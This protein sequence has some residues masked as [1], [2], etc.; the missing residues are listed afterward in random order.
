MGGAVEKIW[1]RLGQEFAKAGNVVVHIS[2]SHEELPLTEKIEGVQHVRVQ[3]YNTP[4]SI[5]RLKT[6]DFIYSWRACRKVPLDSEVVITNTF[7]SPLLL[8]VP[9]KSRIWVSVERMPQGQMRWYRKAR[10]RA[11]SSA[12]VEA[13]Y[14]ELPPNARSRVVMI[15]NP[16]PF[17]VSE[18]SDSLQKQPLLL[19]CGRVHPEKGIHLLIQALHHLK[20]PWPLRVV[21]PWQTEQGGGGQ[22]YKDELIEM[23]KDLPVEWVGPIHDPESLNREYQAAM[24]FIYPSVAERGETFGSAPLEAMAWGCVPIVSNLTCF[25]DFIRS[26]ENGLH[27]DHRK[28]DAAQQLAFAIQQLIDQASLRN[29]LA[30]QAIRVRETHSSESIARQFLNDFAEH[31]Q[32]TRSRS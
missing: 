9:F 25:K 30:R 32:P 5:L 26:G 12:V 7:W 31:I 27:F 28:A 18:P 20:N 17:A 23:A 29:D 24:I 4:P 22:K 6:L 14:N 16:L 19:Y 21:G 8:K 15:P 2:R 10:L 11:N 13:I 3:G 1:F